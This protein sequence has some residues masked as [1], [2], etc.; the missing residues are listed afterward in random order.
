LQAWHT[1]VSEAKNTALNKRE[2]LALVF[3]YFRFSDFLLKSIMI[4]LRGTLFTYED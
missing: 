4:T 1:S 3:S 2:Y